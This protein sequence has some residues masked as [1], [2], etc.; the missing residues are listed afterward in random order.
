MRFHEI[1]VTE[2]QRDRSLKI[3]KLFAECFHQ[4]RE[5]SAM[6]PQR[7][8]LLSEVRSGNPAHVR[9][10][11]NDCLF[12]FHDFGRVVTASGV[13]SFRADESPNLI[14][15]NLGAIQA[16]HFLVLDSGAG[17]ADANA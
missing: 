7:V 9:H 6:H 8:V 11:A 2:I 5:A 13:V 3:F 10:S 12:G 15:F 1:I 14:H 17:R 4:A 16:A